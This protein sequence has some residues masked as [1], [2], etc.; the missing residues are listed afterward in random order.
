[1]QY[2]IQGGEEKKPLPGRGFTAPGPPV[3]NAAGGRSGGGSSGSG[4]GNS[5]SSSGASAGQPSVSV[6]ADQ[7]GRGPSSSAG[8][9]QSS[10][11]PPPPATDADPQAT[12][13]TATGIQAG[14]GPAPAPASVPAASSAGASPAGRPSP[15]D[16]VNIDDINNHLAEPAPAPA[17][18]SDSTVPSGIAVESAPPTAS[19][20]APAV[21][22]TLSSSA[23]TGNYASEVAGGNCIA[24]R[25]KCGS[26]GG[27]T[28]LLVCN[29][30]KSDPAQY[31]E[32]S[33]D[34]LTRGSRRQC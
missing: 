14:A 26:E 34:C 4:S 8:G 29:T 19:A 23:S 22:S 2:Q 10:A 16:A 24:G 12:A 20:G 9:A 31:G 13:P 3:Y 17:E 5:G 6:S 33:G 25:W 11:A 27:K 28:V 1:M 18:G 32:Q 21:S 7:G 15:G 30:L